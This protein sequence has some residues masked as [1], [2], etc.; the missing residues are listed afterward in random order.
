MDGPETPRVSPQSQFELLIKPAGPACNLDCAYCFYLEKHPLS[1]DRAPSRMS[2]ETLER[3]TRQYLEA[4]EGP[5]VTFAWQ[6][7]EPTLMGLDFF[8]LAVALQEQY[9]GG[10]RVRNTLQTN[11]TLLDDQWGAFLAKH[12]FLVG[13]SVDGPAELH[14]AYRVDRHGRPTHAEVMRGLGILKQHGVEFNTLTTVNRTNAREPLAVYQFLKDCGSTYWQ[15]IPVVERRFVGSEQAG[16]H[17]LAVPPGLEGAATG[18][19]LTPWSVDPAAYGEFLTTVF[20]RWVREDVGRVFVQLFDVALGNW[21]RAESSLCLFARECGRG[22]VLEHNGDLFACDHYVDPSYRLGNLAERPLGEL[23][24]RP[25]QQRFGQHK[26]ASLPAYCL[27]CDVR[28]ACH[29]ECPKNRFAT[30]PDGQPGL[31][32]L[33]PAYRRFFRHVDPCMRVMAQFV[34]M[35]Q[36]A[37]RIMSVLTEPPGAQTK[38]RKR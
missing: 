3:F 32:Y 5:E 34:M 29:G 21:L 23:V 9:A 17:A 28:F 36:P 37:A 26:S 4:R 2:P 30:A 19:A 24:T 31:N 25:R 22:P 27:Q 38:R 7:G 6:G 10:K 14:D 1:A 16:P 13:L 8:Q 12:H 35:G 18:H 15:F 20:D 33:C 11:G